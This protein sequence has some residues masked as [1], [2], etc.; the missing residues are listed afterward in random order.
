MTSKANRPEEL[1]MTKLEKIAFEM[2]IVIKLEHVDVTFVEKLWEIQ[3]TWV[4]NN[5]I[6]I[7]KKKFWNT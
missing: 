5:A 2:W 3:I 1:I 7:H 6:R 4:P